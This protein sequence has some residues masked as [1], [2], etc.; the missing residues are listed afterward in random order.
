MTPRNILFLCSLNAGRAMVANGILNALDSPNYRGFAAGDEPDPIPCPEA[1]SVLARHL[2]TV[3]DLRVKHWS[4][5]TQP[6]APKID[7]VISLCD[8]ARGE[9]CPVTLPGRPPMAHWDITDPSS[10]PNIS[11]RQ[12]ALEQVYH[13]LHARILDLIDIPRD[14]TGKNLEKA[15]NAIGWL[16]ARAA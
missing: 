10:A 12:I 15:I 8:N 4:A 14:K 7:V 3:K 9:I 11:A 5:F 2:E 6:G 1:L 13:E 16:N